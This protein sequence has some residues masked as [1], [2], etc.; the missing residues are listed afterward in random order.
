MVYT[1]G[2]SG[3]GREQ[4]DAAGGGD[5][6]SG[7]LWLDPALDRKD[8]GAMA[9]A[10]EPSRSSLAAQE[11]WARTDPETRRKNTEAARRAAGRVADVQETANAILAELVALRAEV[12]DLRR[13][14]VAA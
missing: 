8:H 6:R 3:A 10:V 12:A 14:R 1:N 4:D 2:I 5:H 11:R 9:N 7:D 13:E